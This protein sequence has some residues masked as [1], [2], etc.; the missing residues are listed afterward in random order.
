[1]LIFEMAVIPCITKR[2]GVKS[3]QRL[4]ALGS[5]LSCLA[6]PLLS[7]LSGAGALLYWTSL[8]VLFSNNACSN[9]VSAP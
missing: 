5:G 6:V 3:S 4:A 7:R 1:M 8:L 9:A 2:I